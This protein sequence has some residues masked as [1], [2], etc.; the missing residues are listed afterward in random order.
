MLIRIAAVVDPNPDD[1]NPD[2]P[3]PDDPNPDDLNPDDLN[4]DQI[5][6]DCNHTDARS[7]KRLSLGSLIS[8][9]CFLVSVATV[10]TLWDRALALI[11]SEANLDN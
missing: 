7:V 9:I 11:V 10:W 4:P 3:N 5:N 6:A 2:D 1:P 8:R